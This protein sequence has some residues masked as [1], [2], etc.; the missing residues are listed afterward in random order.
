[1]I[2]RRTVQPPSRTSRNSQ[3]SPASPREHAAAPLPQAELSG[4]SDLAEVDYADPP[5]A[6]W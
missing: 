1:L 6:E 2:G 4:T 3:R 5:S